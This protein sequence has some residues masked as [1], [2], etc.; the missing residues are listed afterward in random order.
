[1]LKNV[2]FFDTEVDFGL[3]AKT[4]IDMF[5]VGGMVWFCHLVIEFF[6]NYYVEA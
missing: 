4:V 3:V 6:G 1:M 2:I 5:V